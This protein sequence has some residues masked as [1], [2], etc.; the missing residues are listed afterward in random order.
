[1][2]DEDFTPWGGGSRGRA[3]RATQPRT[4]YD[5][6]AIR[7][8]A[9]QVRQA[10]RDAQ[11]AGCACG[12]VRRIGTS[13]GE[14]WGGLECKT[15]QHGIV[16]LSMATILSQWRDSQPGLSPADET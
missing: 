5:P 9:E 15:G 14:F 1:M 2:S 10:Y 12:R 7:E 13:A 6:Q 8:R 4:Q 3:Y 11:L 16:Y